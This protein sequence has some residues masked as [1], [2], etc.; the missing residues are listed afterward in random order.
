MLYGFASLCCSVTVELRS[1]HA[2]GSMLTH[3][4]AITQSQLALPCNLYAGNFC[5][6]CFLLMAQ[7]FLTNYYPFPD[8]LSVR[9]FHKLVISRS[10]YHT[11]C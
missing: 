7:S 9:H 8:R 1:R 11:R 6:T 10:A 4:Q 2:F 5:I 3:R